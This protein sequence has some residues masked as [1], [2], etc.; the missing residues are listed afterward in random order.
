MKQYIAEQDLIRKKQRR[1]ALVTDGREKKVPTYNREKQR[2]DQL[3][4][5]KLGTALAA[6]KKPERKRNFKVVNQ[7]GK[8]TEIMHPPK[9]KKRRMG[10]GEKCTAESSVPY[11]NERGEKRPHRP[12]STPDTHQ[13]RKITEQRKNIKVHQKGNKAQGEMK[14]RTPR[15]NKHGGSKT[16][17]IA[18]MPRR[19]AEDSIKTGGANSTMPSMTHTKCKHGSHSVTYITQKG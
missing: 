18:D 17:S 4:P 10:D 1:A 16:H 7:A 9:T 3:V 6:T 12:K 14:K 2:T 5:P 11:T 15:M 19:A 8:P 13:K